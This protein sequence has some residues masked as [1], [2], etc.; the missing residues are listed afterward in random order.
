MMIVGENFRNTKPTH[1]DKGNLIYNSCIVY[2]A[3]HISCPGDAPVLAGRSYSIFNADN[4]S[5]KR[6][7]ASRYGRRADAFPHSSKMNVV[8][9]H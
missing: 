3:V 5:R 4:F 1:D 6:L 7:G 9:K 2:L 8:V